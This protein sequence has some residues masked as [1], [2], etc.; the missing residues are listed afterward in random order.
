MDLSITVTGF[1][2]NGQTVR[3]LDENKIQLRVSRTTKILDVKLNV[4]VGADVPKSKVIMAAVSHSRRVIPKQRVCKRAGVHPVIDRTAI[5]NDRCDLIESQIHLVLR[6][7]AF[8]VSSGSQNNVLAIRGRGSLELSYLIMEVKV[9][10]LGLTAAASERCESDQKRDRDDTPHWS[11]LQ[12][13]RA[14][15][16]LIIAAIQTVSLYTTQIRSAATSGRSINLPV[17]FG[18]DNVVTHSTRSSHWCP[19]VDLYV[20]N[21]K[22]RFLSDFCFRLQ[23]YERFRGGRFCIDSF[24]RRTPRIKAVTQWRTKL[25]RFHSMISNSSNI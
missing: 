4:V 5:L 16:E 21:F 20:A 12:T 9:F 3:R 17:L 14:Q 18:L 13:H 7:L 23:N 8:A 10:G 2:T 24:V 22:L 11:N 1:S 25:V 6:Y 15:K 19:A